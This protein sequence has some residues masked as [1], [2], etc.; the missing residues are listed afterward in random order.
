MSTIKA[1]GSATSN[2]L[3]Q[4]SQSS[5]PVFLDRSTPTLKAVDAQLHSGD[6]PAVVVDLSDSSKALLERTRIAQAIADKLD[7]HMAAHNGG[8][9]AQ[10]PGSRSDDET[11]FSP[12]PSA[13]QAEHKTKW[14][15]GS[16]WGDAT[17]S[18]AEFFSRGAWTSY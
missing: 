12:A 1:T 9:H 11:A 15:A 8:D 2:V 6:R 10:I 18:D 13:P 16:K 7:R 3:V 5:P 17:I 4:L 14:E